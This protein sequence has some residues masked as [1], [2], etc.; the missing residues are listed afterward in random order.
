MLLGGAGV[1]VLDEYAYDNQ[2]LYQLEGHAMAFYDFI[3]DTMQTTSQFTGAG[4]SFNTVGFKPARASYN[5]GGSVALFSKHDWIFSAHYD[6][7]FKED[8]KANSGFLRV[9]H[10]W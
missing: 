6:F 8:Y 5:L 4:P 10:E 9:R 7:N 1:K 2:R 3:G